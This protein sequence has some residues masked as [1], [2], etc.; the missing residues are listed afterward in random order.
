VTKITTVSHKFIQ[1]LP[2][3]PLI[4]EVN[5]IVADIFNYYG[6]QNLSVNRYKKQK[7]LEVNWLDDKKQNHQANVRFDDIAS[8]VQNHRTFD[9]D[10]FGLPNISANW[11]DGSIALAKP[12]GPI[13]ASDG[14][15]HLHFKTPLPFGKDFPVS[16]SLDREGVVFSL[17]QNAIQQNIVRLHSRVIDEC[18][19][20]FE[21]ND[22]SWLHDLRMLLNDCV[23][24]V[25]ITLHQ[26]YLIA[27]YGPRP[28]GWFFDEER[29]GRR[30]S[31][32]L[33]DKFKWIGRITGKPLDD[34]ENEKRTF[35][36]IKNIRNHLNHFDPPCFAFTME[37]IAK[38][39]NRIPDIGRLL[40][41]IRLKLD[42]P[43]T[44]GIVKIITLPL[45]EFVP[46]NP[47]A[48]RLP[49]ANDVGYASCIWPPKLEENKT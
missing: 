13:L 34:A 48:P 26:L 19:K 46:Q 6:N 11:L 32:K 15:R 49:Q 7:Y 25:D 43:L 10:V 30:H 9:A 18:D 5:R 29:L 1:R 8:Y 17:F 2:A 35:Q 47:A 41:K 21:L 23:T 45:V 39:L 31:I 3:K 12:D 40:R 16:P 20:A 44:S 33:M 14:T 28:A 36:F 22:L 27:K 42:V 4:A 38:W 24:I 37:D